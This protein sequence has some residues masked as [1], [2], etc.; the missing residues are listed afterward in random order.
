MI[1]I[2][3]GT[4]LQG[5]GV[6][7]SAVGLW[8]TWHRFASAEDR[9]L[10]PPVGAI[11]KALAPVVSNLSALMR[12]LFRRPP[13][14]RAINLGATVTG[15]G[16]VSIHKTYGPLPA[17]VEE[18][19]TM[20]ARRTQELL[21]LTSECQQSVALEA[22]L[23]RRAADSLRKELGSAVENLERTSHRVALDGIRTQALGLF[24]IAFGLFLQDWVARF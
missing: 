2:H 12:R 23:A 3:V 20:L 9:W 4:W 18:A 1:E 19:L 10:G 17:G 8:R 13:A 5:F 15:E 22:A 21:D 7:A 14:T 11:G 16:S 24:L 6:A